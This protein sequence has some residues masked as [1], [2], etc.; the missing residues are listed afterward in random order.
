MPV[1]WWAYLRQLQHEAQRHADQSGD[2]AGHRDSLPSIQMPELCKELLRGDSIQ[3]SWARIT[4]RAAS[5][6]SAFLRLNILIS[7]VQRITGVHWDTIKR[8]QK[9]IMD[10]TLADRRRKLLREGYRPE[11]LA[12][13]EFAIHK[14]HSYA[15]CVNGSRHR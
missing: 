15:T 7:T 8:I 10:E 3:V 4:E 14:G 11:H 9:E 2:E 13:D 12:V 1:L 5:W 6:I